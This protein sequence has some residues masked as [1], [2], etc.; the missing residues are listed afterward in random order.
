MKIVVLVKEVPDMTRVKF[1]RE[2]GIV[3]RSSAEAEINPFDMNALQAAVDLKK[4]F[5]AEVTVLTMGPPKAVK[6]LKDAYARGADRGV[7][8]T[9]R[10]FGGADTCAT[11]YTLA[12]GIR[13]IEDYDLIICGEKS[14]DGDTAQ[15]GAEV[16][17]FLYLPHSYNVESIDGVTEDSITVTTEKICG[18][19][20][21]RRMKLPA[22]ISVTKNINH[23]QL[24]TVDRKLESLDV[25]MESFGLADLC[26]FMTEEDAGFKGSP[27]KVVKIEVPK[28]ETR[29]S[30]IFRDNKVDFFKAVDSE[31]KKFNIV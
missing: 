10:K 19:N 2:K 5:G 23:P 16:A 15:V 9:D 26:E 29:E 17:E 14:V 8:L 31:F 6:S 28:E 1:D 3:D 24:P 21:K 27:T 20:Q 12:A 4:Q 13:K 30:R 25:E 11:S 18:Y 7:L 22:L